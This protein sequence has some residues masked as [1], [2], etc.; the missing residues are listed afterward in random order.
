MKTYFLINFF[1]YFI[2]K[3]RVFENNYYTYV[4]SLCVCETNNIQKELR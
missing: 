3:E 4:I 1:N 2:E